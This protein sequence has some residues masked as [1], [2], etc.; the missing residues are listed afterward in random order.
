MALVLIL[1]ITE[2]DGKK[3]KPTSN[4]NVPKH[5]IFAP[6]S[7]ALSRSAPLPL[8]CVSHLFMLLNRY[9]SHWLF[10]FGFWLS[11]FAQSQS[12]T[13]GSANSKSLMNSIRSPKYSNAMLPKYHNILLCSLHTLCPPTHPLRLMPGSASSK[14]SHSICHCTAQAWQYCCCLWQ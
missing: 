14:P 6:A 10:Y 4:V 2:V 11:C 12:M 8:G 3:T 1:F 9:G 5:D 7:L 13:E